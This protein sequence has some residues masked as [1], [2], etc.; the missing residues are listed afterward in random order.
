MPEARPTAAERVEATLA[1]IVIAVAIVGATLLPLTTP[2]FVRTLVIAVEAEQITGLGRDLTLE[3]AESVRRFV[4]DPD[5]PPL[6]AVLGG[7]PA[8]DESA[9][10]H[11]LDVRRVLVPARW[12][13]LAAGLLLAAWMGIRRRTS[14]GRCL[15]GTALSTAAGLLVGAAVLGIVVGLA[16][17]DALFSWFHGLFFKPGTWVFPDSALLIRVFPLAFWVTAAAIWGAL[18]LAASGLLFTTG[19][20]MCFTRS[21]YGV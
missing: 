3:A 4:L 10:S 9:V 12:A 15:I 11:L 14:R 21:G 13:T 17:F 20:R 8:F 2:L 16:D 19:R 18:V 1:A 7:Q 5:A 6:P